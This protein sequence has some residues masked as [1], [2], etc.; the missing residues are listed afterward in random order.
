MIPGWDDKKFEKVPGAEDDIMADFRRVP[1]VWSYVTAAKAE[2]SRGKPLP[3]KISVNV[4][5]PKEAVDQTMA[6][7]EMGHTGLG[8]EYSRYSQISGRYERY[9]LKYGFYIAGANLSTTSLGSTRGGRF[10]GQLMDEKDASWTVTRTFPAKTKQI[11]DIIKASETYADKGYNGLTRNCTS[12]VKEMVQDVAHLPLPGNIFEM[13]NP[14][15]SSLGNF[16]VFAGSAHDTNAK[17]N[18]ESRLE[19]LAQK[20]DKSYAGWGNKRV[21]KEDYRNYK[22]HQN[23]QNTTRSLADIPNAV[24]ENMRR[25]EGKGSG[26]ISS[27]LHEGILE[28][29]TDPKINDYIDAVRDEQGKLLD[30]IVKVTGKR[31]LNE[32]FGAISQ[33]PQTMILIAGIQN[34]SQPLTTLMANI[35]DPD[36]MRRARNDLDQQ[37]EELNTLLYE[38]FGN[39]K[40]L[41]VP[42]MHMISILKNAAYYIDTLYGK[43]DYGQNRDGELGNIR[44][45]VK[46]DEFNASVDDINIMMTPSHY[47]AYIQIYKDPETAVRKYSEYAKLKEIKNNKTRSLTSREKD[48]LDKGERMEKLANQFDRA[49][50]YMLE[51]TSY[52]QQDVDYVFSL[53]NKEVGDNVGGDIVQ[54]SASKIYK[55]LILEKIFG[56]MKQRFLNHITDEEANDTAALKS[57]MDDDVYACIHRK[58][59]DVLGVMKAMRRT[60]DKKDQDNVDV[61][62]ARFYA[63]M[64]GSWFYPVFNKDGLEGPLGKLRDSLQ[65]CW[66]GI[67][68]DKKSRTKNLIRS[69]I[70][71]ICSEKEAVDEDALLW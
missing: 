68:D 69:L 70:E 8:L 26:T 29:L 65:D 15:V 1:T 55:V 48:N 24:A 27:N 13:E 25:M 52:S 23:D 71:Q 37:V 59:D 47:E 33:S 22:Q 51:K 10:P 7:L 16:G 43:A 50:D 17:I 39:D 12:F 20:E 49:H 4:N 57:W 64:Q 60:S 19:E 32:L 9:A 45:Q 28:D 35:D 66:G 40:R 41:H 56:G 67:M 30:A 31:D 54:N 62:E 61:M 2:D 11:N 58:K 34:S 14:A 46:F 42:V 3:P 63:L 44:S 6:G 5:Q 18:A 53:G 36:A 38:V 21:T